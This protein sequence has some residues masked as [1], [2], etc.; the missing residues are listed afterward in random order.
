MI[1]SENISFSYADQKVIENLSFDFE[2]GHFV[3]LAGANGVG[4]STLLE[5]ICGNFKP[6]EG[7]IYLDGNLICSYSHKKLAEKL[8]VVRQEF[9][10]PFGFT[11]FETVM[12]ARTPYFDALGF[13]TQKD[14]D[15]TRR[16]LEVTAVSHLADRRLDQISGGERQR[17]FIA[18]ALAQQTPVMLLDEPTSFLDMKHQVGIYDL[19]KKMQLEDGKTII[20]IVHDINLARQYCDKVLLLGSDGNYMFGCAEDIFTK[21]NLKTFYDVDTVEGV[22]EGINILMPVGKLSKA[23]PKLEIY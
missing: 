22:A 11:V 5:L 4:K 2:A 17:V 6:D 18:R 19:L 12:M 8:A 23:K 20:T 9:V 1:Y 13:E 7:K 3:A 10:P 21:E 14:C 15:I 16:S